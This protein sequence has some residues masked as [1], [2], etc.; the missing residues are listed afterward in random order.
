LAGKSVNNCLIDSYE[1]GNNNWSPRFRDEFIKRRGYDPIR[2]LPVLSGRYVES[3]EMTERFLWDFRRTIGDLFAENYFSYFGDLC[4]KHGLKFS[5]EPYEGPF[6]C[7][8]AGAKADIIMGEFWV[9]ASGG[10]SN[11]VKLAASVGHTHGIRIIGSES[12]TARPTDGKWLQHPGALKMQGDSVWCAGI[13]RFI[14]HTYAHQPWMDKI[15]GMTMGQWG[16]HFGRFNTW[17][18]Q[19]RDWLAYVAR[20]QYLLQQGRCVADVLFFAGEASPNG[21][22]MR[23][24]LKAKGYDY[25]AIGTDLMP[26]L[27]VRDR[28]ICTPSGGNYR[29]LV[30][31]ESTWM[32]PALARKVRDL[33]QAGAVVVGP[34]PQKS[35]SLSEYPACDAEVAKIADEV[36]GSTPG[37]HAFGKGRIVWGGPVDEILASMGVKPDFAALNSGAKT[38]Y[39]HRS[40]DATDIYFISNQKPLPQSIDCAFRVA[41]RLP[42]LWNAETGYTEPAP[43]WRVEDGR[44]IVTLDLEQAGS[45]FVVFRQAAAAPSDPIVKTARQGGA[46]PPGKMTKL[47]I[48]RAIYGAFKR[49]DGGQVDVTAK[50][51]KMVKDGLLQATASNELAGDPAPNVV[52]ELQIEYAVDG[53]VKSAVFGEGQEFKLPEG[54]AKNS[55]NLEIRRAIYGVIKRPDRG[56][57]DVTG[58]LKKMV[59]DG[60]LQATVSNEL[61][62]DPAPNAAKELRIEYTVDGLAQSAVFGEGQ[63][64]QLPDAVQN[65][66][67]PAPHLL[68]EDGQL[69]LIAANAGR[70]SFTTASGAE[71]T[72]TIE[73]IP[74]PV[75]ITGSWELTFP[76]GRGAPDRATFD[77]LISWPEHADAGIKYFSGTATYR[78]TIT[79]PAALLGTDRT[80]QLDLGNVKEIAEVRLNGKD[81]GILWK[82][83]FRV[84]ITRA[85]KAGNNELEVRVTNLWPNRLIGDEQLPEDCEWNGIVLKGWPDWML[86]GTTRPVP[87]RVTFTTWKHWTKDSPLLPSGLLGPVVLRNLVKIPVK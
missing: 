1:V 51:K 15:P 35:P 79:I 82:S 76:A 8:Q 48:S 57:V 66:S 77:S 87:G 37:E 55:S 2:F 13:N 62:G 80:L 33:V 12:F 31:P 22:V 63:E 14:F 73:S 25:D 40:V 42:E 21:N 28:L 61:A 38:A 24:D 20:S 10:V 67:P 45:V 68:L 9:G 78:K 49:P 7:L 84:D 43:I 74:E 83:P 30:L 50:L 11:S 56:Q 18:E 17:W 29:I 19:S 4:R 6:E 44:T 46:L 58:K 23:P 75:K 26:A 3:G 60:L 81:L 52:K 69:R 27:S 86:K 85:A 5:V 71:K 36:W 64:F 47:E 54:S 32:T 59:K 16:T 72:A 41:G 34:K 65:M 39:I 53:V 70:Y